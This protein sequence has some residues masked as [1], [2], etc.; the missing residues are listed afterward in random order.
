MVIMGPFQLETFQDP[1]I[2]TPV[3]SEETHIRRRIVSAT[4]RTILDFHTDRS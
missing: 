4:V 2:L 3:A 1:V